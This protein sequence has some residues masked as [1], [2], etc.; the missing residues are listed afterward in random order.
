MP[1]K[2]VFPLVLHGVE[3]FV[4]WTLGGTAEIQCFKNYPKCKNPI[5]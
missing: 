2:S 1:C 4:K 5:Q 3:D